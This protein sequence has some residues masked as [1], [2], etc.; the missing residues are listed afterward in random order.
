MNPMSLKNNLLKFKN[1]EQKIVLYILCIHHKNTPIS[2]ETYTQQMKNTTNTLRI[3]DMFSQI[4]PQTPLGTLVNCN[5]KW[6]KLTYPPSPPPTI[7]IPTNPRN[8]N[9]EQ[10]LPLK[11]S[12]Q[13]CYYTDGSFKP[14]KQTNNGQHRREKIGYGIYNPFKNLKVAKGLPGLQNILRAE[15]MAI[16]HT[17]QLLTTTY[18]NELAHIFTDYL[19]ILFLLNT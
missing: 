11:F 19:N 8:I 6:T 16:H 4:A 14:P 18:R 3:P 12:P 7:Q 10:C 9:P 13:F 15:M 2:T 5:T 1:L 17:L